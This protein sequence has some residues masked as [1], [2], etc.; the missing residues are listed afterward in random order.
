MLG[1]VKKKLHILAFARLTFFLFPP[2]SCLADHY[3]VMIKNGLIHDGTGSLSYHADVGIKNGRIAKI[4]NLENDNA[5]R[6]IDAQGMIVAPGFVDVHT[7]VEERLLEIPEAENFVR[8]GVTT[9]ITGN[10]GSS[11]VDTAEFLRKVEKK[12]VSINVGTLIGHGSVRNRVMGTQNRD[13]R[14]KELEAMG[15]LVERAMEDG[16][17]GL[18]TG[19][20]YV[21]GTYAKTEEIV[22]LA[23]AAAQYGGVYATH[24]R[25]EGNKVFEALEEAIKIGEQARLPIQISHFKVSSK[26]KWGESQ[27][28]LRLVEEARARGLDITVDQYAYTASSTSLSVLLPSWALE[29]G[30]KKLKE[31]LVDPKQKAKMKEEMAQNLRESGWDDYFY[32]SVASYRPDPSLNGNNIKEIALRKRYRADLDDQM[33]QVF[34]ME[35]A[36]KDSIA[37]IYHKMSEED[38]QRIL[39][40]PLTMIASDGSV[41]QVGDGVPHPRGYGNNARVLGEYVRNK[42]LIVLE[43]AIRKMTSLPAQVFQIKGRGLLR[44]GMWADVVI[45]DAQKVTDRATFENPHQYPEGIPYVLVNGVP[46]VWEGKH[47]RAYP[48]QVIHGPGK[49]SP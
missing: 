3:D 32:A 38:V 11:Q 27:N 31:R 18:S 35:L 36:S 25:D 26:K 6:T 33:E 10:C 43:E 14:Q 1:K 16:A 49:S 45:F 13:P 23:R 21:P 30:K 2:A 24:L 47:S 7:H 22:E 34:K 15:Q 9:V 44:E 5:E 20:I 40:H 48:G 12:K 41:L 42:K 17:I 8:M 4:G 39:Q 46:V 37:M 29:G 19:L 28:S